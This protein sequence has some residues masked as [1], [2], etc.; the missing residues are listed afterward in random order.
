[1]YFSPDRSLD[2]FHFLTVMNNAAINAPAW[3]FVYVFISLRYRSKSVTAA[4]CGT[5]CLIIWGTARLTSKAVDSQYSQPQHMRVAHF[6]H[7][8][9][10][11]FYCLTCQ[12]SISA[13]R[14]AVCRPRETQKHSSS[15]RKQK[16]PLPWSVGGCIAWVDQNHAD[17]GSSPVLPLLSLW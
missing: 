9:S 6:L 10:N 16:K 5:L 12:F 3:V 8:L 1:M 13:V 7:I 2:C 11:I 4:S 14:R 15:L 17:G